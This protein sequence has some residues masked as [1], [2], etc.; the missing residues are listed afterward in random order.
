MKASALDK[1]VVSV[2]SQS[3]NTELIGLQKKER[4]KPP[5]VSSNN[6][7]N[8]PIAAQLAH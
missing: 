5:V 4:E 8:T 7:G 1:S 6:R 3:Y 2:P